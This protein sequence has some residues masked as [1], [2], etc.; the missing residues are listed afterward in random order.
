MY[1]LFLESVLEMFSLESVSVIRRMCIR[2]VSLERVSVIPRKCIRDVSLD[3][4][5]VIPRKCIS[6]PQKVYQ[7]SL[8]SVSE[9]FP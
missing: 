9:L 7:L 4:V 5:S 3:S 2:V 1:Q 6:Y 8:E